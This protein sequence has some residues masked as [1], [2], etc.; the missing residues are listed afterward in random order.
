[1]AQAWWSAPCSI[2]SNAV[3]VAW[4][5]QL[6]PG[7]DLV[8]ML[9]RLDDSAYRAAAMLYLRPSPG[10]E[11][12]ILPAP[13]QW[14]D[15]DK[16]A[17][18]NAPWALEDAVA[19]NFVPVTG[20]SYISTNVFMPTGFV[21]EAFG[22]ATGT[23]IWVP[24]GETVALH[25]SLLDATWD[26][27][28]NVYPEKIHARVSLDSAH[29]H[30]SA[31]AEFVRSDAGYGTHVFGGN[32]QIDPRNMLWY[33]FSL[34]DGDYVRGG[35]LDLQPG[36][37]IG[38][39]R[40]AT[41]ADL[42]SLPRDRIETPDGFTVVSVSN[43]TAFLSVPGSSFEL[44]V[45]TVTD[46]FGLSPAGIFDFATADPDPYNPN[47]DFRLGNWLLERFDG[48]WIL[49]LFYA[50]GVTDAFDIQNYDSIRPTLV[51][52]NGV[53]TNG[54]ALTRRPILEPA[55]L[56]TED[57]IPSP[58]FSAANAALVATIQ[59][60]SPAPG[61]YATVSNR[62]MSALQ[63]FTESDPTVPS[64]AKAPAKPTYTASEVGAA[65]EAHEHAVSDI[66]NFPA[67]ATVAT[68][69]A[70]A[71]LSGKP[72]IP[73]VPTVVSAFSNDIGYLTGYT[74]SDPTVPA[75]AKADNPPSSGAD[76]DDVSNLV[77]QVVSEAGSSAAATETW[78][79]VLA[80]H[81]RRLDSLEDSDGTDALTEAQA[82][83]LIQDRMDTLLH[84]IEDEWGDTSGCIPI[85][86]STCNSTTIS[87]NTSGVAAELSPLRAT[88]YYASTANNRTLGFASFSGVGNNPCILILERFSSVTWP[89]GAKVETAYAYNSGNPNVYAVY[90]LNG[91]IYAKK[92]YP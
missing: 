65:A 4:T 68:S 51:G 75:W 28:T 72:A 55:R 26:I 70:Y 40:L 90:K 41:L 50:G 15:F 37:P 79:I 91:V 58:D 82:E 23:G 86:T 17:W 16:V 60:V 84:D 74:E 43:G 47:D 7:A 18:T 66:T 92:L 34:F 12:N 33:W 48:R 3:T 30:E 32:I 19:T 13:T 38:F 10:A 64:W 52:R 49:I 31:N 69:G 9:I 6:D 85:Q 5:P 24:A 25:L 2:A 29:V 59:A 88:R 1:M 14:I 77:A 20:G 62:A 8:S 54:L 81:Q 73:T 27:A 46:E 89:T 76:M 63:S 57:Q 78:R 71:D 42:A 11:P 67:L 61:N 39:S 87:A 80:D 21:D 56:V 44:P 53:H 36:N 83:Q 45:L 35:T 22:T